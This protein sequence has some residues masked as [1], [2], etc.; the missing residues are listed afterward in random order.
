MNNTQEKK[1]IQQLIE[2]GKTKGFLTYEEVSTLLPEDMVSSEELDSLLD[3]LSSEHIEVVDKDGAM[4]E[5]RRSSGENRELES[6]QE[7]SDGQDVVYLSKT[8]DPVRMYLRKMGSV[9]L[10]TREGEV[11]IAKRIEQGD[12]Q[13]LD[14]L[15]SSDIAIQNIIGLGAQLKQD[16]IRLKDVV[17]KNSLPDTRS[18]QEEE[19]FVEEIDEEVGLQSEF[20]DFDDFEDNRISQEEADRRFLEAIDNI[21]MMNRDAQKLAIQL[22][23]GKKLTERKRETITRE[24]NLCKRVSYQLSVFRVDGRNIFYLY[25]SAGVLGTVVF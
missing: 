14:V 13:V 5:R 24:L 10:L 21:R 7:S 25:Q 4:A 16:K 6:T 2:L 8:S 12:R 17:E 11:E 22:R 9:C 3:V 18:G 1:T 23:N 20:D 15:L 19:E